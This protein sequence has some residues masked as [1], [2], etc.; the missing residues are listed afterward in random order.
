MDGLLNIS[1]DEYMSLDIKLPSR[2]EQELIAQYIGNIDNLITLH[3]RKDYGL[4]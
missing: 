1:Y 4:K 2:A 3:Q